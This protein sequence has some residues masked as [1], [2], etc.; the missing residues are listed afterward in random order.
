MMVAEILRKSLGV[1][2]TDLQNN[3][4]LREIFLKE[5]KK[6]RVQTVTN[7]NEINHW[8]NILNSQ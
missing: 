4:D 6:D 8:L 5:M 2:E 7:Q 3:S 1:F